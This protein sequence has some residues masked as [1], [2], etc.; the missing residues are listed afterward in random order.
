MNPWLDSWHNV[1]SKSGG[2][3]H[4]LTPAEEQDHFKI[5]KRQLVPTLQ[6]FFR[7]K[8]LSLSLHEE[9]ER[10]EEEE[11]GHLVAKLIYSGYFSIK[12]AVWNA[13]MHSVSSLL[14]LKK[15]GSF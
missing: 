1:H 6:N 5:Y 7:G 14:G 8:F 13:F 12:R 3:A 4:L 15:L 10:E 2:P 11:G 9:E